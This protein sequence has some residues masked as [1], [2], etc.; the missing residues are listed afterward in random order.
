MGP[1]PDEGRKEGSRQGGGL[2]A[3]GP[4]R[5]L[6]LLLLRGWGWSWRWS[7]RWSWSGLGG[8]PVGARRREEAAAARVAGGRAA[9]TSLVNKLRC[10]LRLS[11]PGAAATTAPERLCQAPAAKRPSASAPTSS[12]LTGS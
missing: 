12:A 6:L 10:C 3:L 9:G 8:A 1:H 2:P 4:P 11:G 5:S 7:W